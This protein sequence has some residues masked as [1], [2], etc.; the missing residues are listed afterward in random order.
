[1]KRPTSNHT[2]QWHTQVTDVIDNRTYEPRPHPS[3]QAA[4]NYMKDIFKRRKCHVRLLNPAG[5]QMDSL[6]YSREEELRE[7]EEAFGKDWHDKWK[8]HSVGPFIHTGAP[9]PE[10]A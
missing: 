9:A 10:E 2:P 7:V 6:S 8:P 1:M 3:E 4:R 5:Q